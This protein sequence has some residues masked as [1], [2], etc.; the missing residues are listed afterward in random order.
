MNRSVTFMP[1]G[2]ILGFMLL[3]S[4]GCARD[5]ENENDECTT[6]PTQ[7]A[8]QCAEQSPYN[9]PTDD[10]YDPWNYIFKI[11]SD[12]SEWADFRDRLVQWRADT[13]AALNYTGTVYDNPDI[14][15]LRAAFL[16][17]YVN[18][19]NALYWDGDLQRYDIDRYLAYMD[20]KFGD[21]DIL[22]LGYPY[23]LLGID[24]R[25]QWDYFR[26]VPGGMQGFTEMIQDIQDRDVATFLMYLPWDSDTRPEDNPFP[27]VALDFLSETGSMGLFVDTAA[28]V[29]PGT[30]DLLRTVNPRLITGTEAPPPLEEIEETLFSLMVL[31]E[32][33]EFGVIIP[34]YFERRH[35]MYVQAENGNEN[36]N[37]NYE[38]GVHMAFFNGCGFH[39][40][41]DNYGDV[42]PVTP[43]AQS[44]VRLTIPI[45]RRY[46]RFF[47]NNEPQGWTPLVDTLDADI[48]ASLW[49]SGETRIWTLVNRSE[50]AR[51]GDVMVVES[52]PGEVFF[53]LIT[54]RQTKAASG[55]T[56]RLSCEMPAKG[57]CAFLAGDETGPA[58]EDFL[59]G[60]LEIFSTADWDGAMPEVEILVHE[61]P[62]TAPYKTVPAGMTGF[63]KNG[64]IMMEHRWEGLIPVELSPFAVDVEPV[65][66]RDYHTFITESGYVPDNIDNYLI[67]FCGG[68]T[69]RP[70]EDEAESPVT[71]VS[72]ADA[73]A[74]AA[75]AGK[76]LLKSMEYQYANEQGALQAGR[77][78]NWEWTG[79]VI[80]NRFNLIVHIRGFTEIQRPQCPG[81]N[82]NGENIWRDNFLGYW[83]DATYPEIEETYFFQEMFLGPPGMQRFATLGFRCG[84]DLE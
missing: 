14:E 9:P 79:D 35:T 18:L 76:R 22:G 37:G 17:T 57:V 64:E 30:L 84:V 58:F 41:E 5:A 24:G 71:Y 34:K 47:S 66:N 31:T 26:D 11:P 56:T 40:E 43:R 20:E 6:R 13:V 65:T 61:P 52:R 12:P 19:W 28:G 75:W 51:S 50:E 2:Y 36:D 8:H 81:N 1:L 59:A 4:T 33:D 32:G 29:V 15:W 3:V 38:N 63:D 23:S 27:G 54:G 60:Q 82:E 48:L 70:Y 68:H 39:P 42:F 83:P 69:G 49:R 25:S 72:L 55:S 62:E 67:Q 21:L 53:D 7:P 74:Y 73:S 78:R 10:E 16:K 45:L 80:E 44:L 77:T 46:W